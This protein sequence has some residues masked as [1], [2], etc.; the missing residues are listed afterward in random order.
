MRKTIYIFSDGE[1]RR[2]EN[3]IYFEGEEGKRKYIPI[4]NTGELLIFGEVSFNK[5]MLEFFTQNEIILHFYNRYG[6]YI[7][8]FYP[9]EHY[10][11]G[12]IILRQ[13][14]FYLDSSRRFK[15]ALKFVN[16]AISNMIKVLD[17]YNA[18]GVDLKEEVE[19]LQSFQ[20]TLEE[21]SSIETLMAIEGNAKE[22]YYKSFNKII[23]RPEFR[24]EG[25]ER[26]PPRDRINALISFGN[27]LIYTY[28]LSEI[29]KTHL[30]PRIGFL[31]ASN[32]RR[33]SLNLDIAEIFKP[34]LG[35][36]VIF[37]IINKGML[38]ENHFLRE[39]GGLYLNEDGRK[40]FIEEMEEKLNSTVKHSKLGRNVSYRTLIRLELLK[41]E[42]HILGE[43]GYEPFVARW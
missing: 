41:L 9:R 32:F 29:Y 7:G 42:K 37:S 27:S 43:E 24:F 23:N 4:E 14:Q 8:S 10:N 25:R 11:S 31:H 12:E 5:R 1:I 34:I 22:A 33:F 16:G 3:T 20:S 38:K 6:Y 26:R 30:D 40:L 15:L 13:V 19:K 35:D 28:C 17:Y 36:R 39:L 21:L 18:R 2:K